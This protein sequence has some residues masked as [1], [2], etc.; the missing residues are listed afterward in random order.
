[1]KTFSALN[2]P[3]STALAALYVNDIFIFITLQ[4]VG[5]FRLISS[6]TQEVFRTILF[7]LFSFLIVSDCGLLKYLY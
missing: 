7:T 4:I 6:F 1:M 3:L 5:S 2:L